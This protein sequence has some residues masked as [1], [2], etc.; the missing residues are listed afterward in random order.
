MKKIILLLL[1][2]TGFG[3]NASAQVVVVEKKV[4]APR[5]VVVHKVVPP[6]H[7]VVKAKHGKH[8][9][10]HPKRARTVVIPAP[11]VVVVKR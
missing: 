2:F 7:A 4:V 10:H 11:P 1:V 6:G 8:R 3:F 5:P 9:K